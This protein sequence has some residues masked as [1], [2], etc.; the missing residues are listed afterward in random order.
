MTPQPQ[1]LCREQ[2]LQLAP[3]AFPALPY[4]SYHPRETKCLSSWILDLNPQQKHP[5]SISSTLQLAWALVLAAYTDCHDVVFG[6]VQEPADPAASVCP[7]H[8]KIQP[9]LAVDKAL[10][11]LDQH[12]QLY[13][14][15]QSSP[16]MAGRFPN[17]LAIRHGPREVT[18]ELNNV[19]SEIHPLLVTGEV[20][21]KGLHIHMQ[22]DPEAISPAM[23]QTV[24]DQLVHAVDGIRSNP[25]NRLESLLGIGPVGLKQL[26]LWN[27]RLQLHG[28]ESCI[29]DVIAEKCQQHPSALAICA[30]DGSLTYSELDA[31]STQLADRLTAF[32]PEP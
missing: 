25:S 29:H 30:W 19:S 20:L 21:D 1:H 13:P 27:S 32:S 18:A 17:A 26:Q 16:E 22:Y 11:L 6:L 5:V 7:V 28:K 9:D 4:D 23:G 2:H 12:N 3:T 14:H 15:H 10:A 31:K 8:V 24:L